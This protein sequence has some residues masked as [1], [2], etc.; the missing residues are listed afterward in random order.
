MPARLSIVFLSLLV[1]TT[2]CI[3]ALKQHNEARNAAARGTR[4]DAACAARDVAALD[5]MQRYEPNHV[6]HARALDCFLRLKVEA[7]EALEC[8]AFAAAFEDEVHMEGQTQVTHRNDQSSLASY[9]TD[10]P[11]DRVAAIHTRIAR[12]ALGCRAASVLFSQRRV[13]LGGGDGSEGSEA[14]ARV[15]ASLDQPGLYGLLVSYVRRTHDSLASQSIVTWLDQTHGAAQCGEL[16]GA[17]RHSENLRADLLYFFVRKHCKREAH[18]VASELLASPAAGFRA[19]ACM[20]LR[21]LD[22]RSELSR[23]QLL[24]TRDTARELEAGYSG[25]WVIGYVSFPVREACQEA[26]NQLVLRR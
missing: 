12:K 17:T 18:A 1:A 23:M 15:F 11:V 9:L 19:R 16:E 8:P 14:W 26:I 21:D 4:I 2:G 5:E 3:D 10:Q 25:F 6:N 24:A 13:T 20:A 7:L 22:D